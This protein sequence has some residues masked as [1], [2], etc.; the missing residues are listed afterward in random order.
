[1]SAK[2]F[3]QPVL[4]SPYEYP[5]RHWRLENGVPTDHVDDWRRRSEYVVPVP[6]P[7]RRRGGPAQDAMTLGVEGISTAEQEYDPTPIINEIRRR[8][9]AW[10][11]LP[12]PKDWRVSSVTQR[13]LRH[14][15]GTSHEH[16]GVRPFFCQV[17]AVETVIWLT[18]VT[19]ILAEGRPRVAQEFEN[20]R[21]HLEGANEQANSELL[22]IALKLATGAGKTTVMAML[23]AWQAANAARSPNARGFTDKFLIVTPGITI[24]DRLRVLLPNDP[25]N[26]YERRDL[27]PDDMLDAVRRAKVVITNY[28]AF[29]PREREGLAAG[30]RDLL[31]G[32]SGDGPRTLETE[33]QMLRR[34]MRDLLGGK[35]GVL[36]LNDEGHHCYR[37]KQGDSKERDLGAEEREE[38]KRNA[39]AARLWI[40]GL[41]AAKR[42]AGVRAVIDLSATPFFL[43]GSGYAEGTLFPWT[44]NDFSLMDAIESGIV[45]V[46]R[47]PVADDLPTGTAPKFRN[48]WEHVGKRL[49][50]AGRSGGG[51]LDPL[52]LPNDLRSALDALYSH[53]EQTSEQWEAAGVRTPPVFIVVCNNTAT[54][55]LV[56]DYIAGFEYSKR[57]DGEARP[58]HLGALRRFRNYDADGSRLASPRTLLI[59]SAQLESGDALSKEFR[60][61]EAG[62][63]AQFR[64]ERAQRSGARADD[65]VADAELL[66]EVLNTVGKEGRLGA[67]IRCVVSVSMLTEGWDANTV[68]HVLGVRAFGTQL[69]CEQVV[70]RALRRRSYELN[71]EGLFTAEYAD[72]LGV[73]FDFTAQPSVVPVKPPASVVRVHAVSPER[74]ALKIVFPRVTGYR[75]ETPEDRLDAD[76]DADSDLEL[77]PELVGPTN[78][79]NEGIVGEGVTLTPEYL[80]ATR[81]KTVA[82]HLAEHLLN[83]HFRKPGEPPEIAVFRQLTD[84]TTRWMDEGRLRCLGDTQPAQ[85]LYKDVADRAVERIRTAIARNAERRRDGAGAKPLVRA[86]PDPYNPTGSTR[87]VNFTTSKRLRWETRK[88][89][90]NWAICDS[91]W[92]AEF[93]RV[94]EE[95][96]RVLAYVKNNGMGFGVPYYLGEVQKTYVPDFIVLLDDGKGWDAPRRVVVE[97]KGYRREDDVDKANAMRSL[98]IPGVNALGGYGRWEFVELRRVWEMQ[99]EFQRLTGKPG[100]AAFDF[101]KMLEYAPLEGVDLARPKD[102][103]RDVSFLLEEEDE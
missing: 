14:W 94:A 90:V 65:A 99:E 60:E 21:L 19:K 4:N 81:P 49:P 3:E 2:F 27:M 103:G 18:E 71:D 9:D 80:N 68:T 88:S 76:F 32:R 48:L 42:E 77:T 40:T 83:R 98:W 75:T 46:P 96:P 51:D 34:V 92:E 6:K 50:R 5:G 70:G 17:E 74:D 29:R 61:M 31:R 63:V 37:E 28:H 89:H 85:L 73:P 16:L 56:Y 93:C 86:V 30:T 20:I 24:R 33:G 67:N 45:K 52:S 91:E 101:K 62:A 53:Y 102:Y 95:D 64:R 44:V 26:Y 39:E 72:V 47:V 87:Q 84:I 82:F 7:K 10:R 11:A 22:R 38:A 13:L 97:T 41:E 43:R 54:S 57:D 100:L 1:M 55:K 12:N 15:R 8:V 79:R 78:T 59:D 23:I 25:E 35:R 69:L 36:A 58:P 66:R